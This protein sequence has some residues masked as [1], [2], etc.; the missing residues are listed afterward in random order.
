LN[1][2]LT[3]GTGLLG[4]H[5]LGDLRSRKHAV[6]ALVR[7]AGGASHMERLGA[8]PLIGSVSDPASWA[9]VARADAIVHGA[10]IVAGRHDWDAFE[11]TNVQGTGLAVECALRLG[12]PLIHISSVA[13]YGRVPGPAVIDE[14]VAFGALAQREYY[15]RSK[16]ASEEIVW[17]AMKRGLQAVIIRPCVIYGEGDRLFTPGIVRAIR[18]G[19]VPLVG[20]GDRPLALVYAG[21]VAHAVGLALETTTAFG[22]AYNITND[23]NITARK[24]AGLIAQGLGQSIHP[25]PI[26]EMVVIPASIVADRI[27]RFFPGTRYPASVAGAVRFWRGGNRYTSRRAVDELGWKPVETHEAAVPRC[28]RLLVGIHPG[29]SKEKGPDG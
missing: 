7:D 17:N 22:Q 24:L 21:N 11:R 25:I 9:G 4:Q 16:R 8:V 28:A 26:P 14:T 27:L 29:S 6:I 13:V 23:G 20:R 15:A 19:I 12:V 3:G 1:I 18:R 2:Y 10:A 5:I